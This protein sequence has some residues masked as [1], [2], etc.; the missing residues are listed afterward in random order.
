MGT[1]L[2]VGPEGIDWFCII[3]A[4]KGKVGRELA[5]KDEEV[6]KYEV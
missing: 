2:K 6:P 5:R 1:K 4:E 3:T